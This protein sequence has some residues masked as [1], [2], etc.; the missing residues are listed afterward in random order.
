MDQQK[1]QSIKYWAEDDRPREKFLLKGRAALSDAELLAIILGSGSR[2]ES[3]VELA[4]RV[5][6]S[7]KGNLIE[8]GR[9]NLKQLMEF[10]G[11]GEAKAISIAAALEIG[12]R[13]REQEFFV[14][15]KITSSNDVFELMH[16]DLSD[17]NI[18]EFWIVI[19]N[20]ANKVLKKIKISSGGVSGTVA[21]TRVIFKSAIDELASAII[22]VH[23][24]PSGNLKPSKADIS[25]T[26]KLKSAGEVLDI[27]T[28]D[29]LIIA[30]NSYFSF[31]DEGLL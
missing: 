22:L 10:N 18:E 27:P 24:H 25:L 2:K 1:S 6:E 28:L 30:E 15:E 12:R 20:R 23:N 17:L 14:K 8:L 3:A 29:H 9:Y 5:L 19:L 11:I 31:A 7:A 13:R 21:D 26:K 16:G 4:K